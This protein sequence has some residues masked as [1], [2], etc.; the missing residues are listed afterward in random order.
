MTAPCS[1]Q[2]LLDMKLNTL[3]QTIA[4]LE[5][6]ACKYEIDSTQSVEYENKLNELRRHIKEQKSALRSVTEEISDYF[7]E[8]IGVVDQNNAS[9]DSLSALRKELNETMYKTGNSLE[10]KRKQKKLFYQMRNS[11]NNS[12]NSEIDEWIGG[13]SRL[14][15][16]IGELSRE[17]TRLVRE[18]KKKIASHKLY[19]EL[20][21]ILRCRVERKERLD[22][23]I[24]NRQKQELNTQIL[25]EKR[26]KQKDVLHDKLEGIE[27]ELVEYTNINLYSSPS[28]SVRN[29][30]TSLD[31]VSLISAS[32]SAQL[33]AN[34]QQEKQSLNDLIQYLQDCLP[35]KMRKQIETLKMKMTDASYEDNTQ[36]DRILD[37]MRE[38]LN[39]NH[40]RDHFYLNHNMNIFDQFDALDVKI[41][42][43][44]SNIPHAIKAL[45]HRLNNL[46]KAIKLFAIV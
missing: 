4:E 16:Q 25:N 31:N 23:S 33:E 22:S 9:A 32:D 24:K 40:M 3:K 45:L 6:I 8:R 20:L 38:Q 18:R 2:E 15:S 21:R 7:T 46:Q 14:V 43:I 19:S 27:S 11:Y 42:L 44:I 5:D 35:L 37:Q 1:K 29:S 36:M 12:D 41:P 13:R 28:V 39:N 26:K 34:D 17:Y 10:L 30:I